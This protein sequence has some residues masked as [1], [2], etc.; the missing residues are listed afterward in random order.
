MVTTQAQKAIFA[1]LYAVQVDN[2]PQLYAWKPV[3]NASE[4]QSVGWKM[5]YRLKS[6]YGGH[7]IWA[8]KKLI[9]DI[10]I[11]QS[12]MQ[13]ALELFWGQQDSNFGQ[14]V[15]IQE[16]GQW[17]PV[18]LTIAEFVASGLT[19]D[20]YKA[21]W[22]ILNKYR[23]SI[24]GAQ[25]GREHYIRGW[26]MGGI[27]VISI[28]ISSTITS[29]V[30]FPLQV[31]K[32]SKTDQNRVLGLFVRDTTSNM[33]GEIV[34]VVGKLENHR[35][36]L[37]RLTSRETMREKI[38]NAPD[39]DLVVKIISGNN[40]YDYI[41]SVLEIIVRT[42]DYKRL[43]I[44]GQQALKHL[45][46]NPEL[47]FQI[48]QEIADILAQQ[49]YILPKAISN[50]DEQSQFASIHTL[51]VKLSVRLG[52]G[53]TCHADARTVLN[54]LKKSP[55]YRRTNSLVNNEPLKVGILN[56]IGDDSRIPSYLNDIRKQLRAIHF[57]VEFT[58]A[59]R[60]NSKSQFEVEQAVDKLAQKSPNI[61]IVFVPGMPVDI[62]NEDDSLYIMLKGYMIGH[63]IQSQFIYEYTLDKQYALSNIILGIVAKTGNV[64]YVLDQPLPYA[65]IV[66]GIDVA[67]IATRRR[68]GSMS[69]PAVTRIYTS[70]GDFLRY[71]LNESPIEGET[72]PKAV[73]RKLFPAELFAGKNV[74]VHRD[75]PFRGE[76]MDHLYEWGD[77]IGSDFRLVE[78]IKSGSP[79]IYLNSKS[80]QRPNKGDAIILNTQEA[81]LVSSLPPHKNSTPRPLFVRTDGKVTIEQALHSILSLTLMHF[82]SI[83]QPRLPVTI[84][85]S[86][87]I[88]YLALQ[89]IKPKNSEGTKPYWI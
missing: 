4:K 3:I 43:Q 80:I 52:D 78:V 29:T 2:L 70:D 88:G 23:R 39:N 87:R 76:E 41:T 67:R 12:K 27:P 9:A 51:G 71:L 77:E 82:G 74:L 49:D 24:T 33:K 32:L 10:Q 61:I 59:E 26:D 47:R 44:N 65:D 84:H 17:Q 6:M 58:D 89:G 54:E 48:V 31:Q 62:D 57:D 55:V 19:S 15:S 66:A 56:F 86:D 34:D 1:E 63:D 83:M 5:A 13:N 85:Y 21:I 68:L 79:R 75:G 60:P 42:K 28:S 35:Q 40:E 69:I 7:W 45:Q 18:S 30:N 64:P 8:E 53:H 46:I 37:E 16:D 38:H 72:L 25:I 22:N 14:V 11:T 50:V 73:I 20:H 81:I 36:R